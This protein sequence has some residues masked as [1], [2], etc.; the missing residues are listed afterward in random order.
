[1]YSLVFASIISNL[2]ALIFVSI[3]FRTQVHNYLSLAHTITYITYRNSSQYNTYDSQTMV[4]TTLLLSRT[5][6]FLLL[7]TDAEVVFFF[8]SGIRLH[9]AYV[10]PIH[11][12]EII[13]DLLFL[14]TSSYTYFVLLFG[15]NRL[16]SAYFCCRQFI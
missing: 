15:N 9:T 11:H 14:H 6:N 7:P 12:V 3:N 16:N 13:K 2:L 4:S 8:V 10:Y 1:M 5:S